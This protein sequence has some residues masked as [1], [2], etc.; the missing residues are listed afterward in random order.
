MPDQLSLSEDTHNPSVYQT[1]L[2][3]GS[4]T[5]QLAQHHLYTRLFTRHVKTG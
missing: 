4:D 1:V 5:D 3:Q 2:T